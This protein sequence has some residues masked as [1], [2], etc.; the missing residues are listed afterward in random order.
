MRKPTPWKAPEG[1]QTIGH[2]A[3][4]PASAAPFGA[5]CIIRIIPTAY[6]VGYYLSPLTGLKTVKLALSL[7]AVSQTERVI[8]TRSPEQAYGLCGR[9]IPGMQLSRMMSSGRSDCLAEEDRAALR[10]GHTAAIPPGFSAGVDTPGNKYESLRPEE[11]QSTFPSH[12]TRIWVPPPLA[13]WWMLGMQCVMLRTT[14]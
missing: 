12:R 10:T 2:G 5:E 11:Y 3:N 7:P 4:S 6:A 14:L 13:T 1:R 9:P 8:P